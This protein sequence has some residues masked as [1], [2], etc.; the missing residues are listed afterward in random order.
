MSA[1]R[2][3]RLHRPWTSAQPA[4]VCSAG[5]VPRGEGINMICSSSPPCPCARAPAARSPSAPPT[6][7]C[8]HTECSQGRRLVI[9]SCRM[10]MVTSLASVQR[11]PSHGV[12]LPL[13][14]C[15]GEWLA[16]SGLLMP[17]PGLDPGRC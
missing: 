6:R 3:T 5:C 13:S 1:T 16:C 14:L 4:P 17:L 15:R 7:L 9:I 11:H 12:G 10:Q 8:Q 2:T